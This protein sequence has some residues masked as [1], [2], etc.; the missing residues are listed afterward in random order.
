MIPARIIG[1]QKTTWSKETLEQLDEN[2]QYL[3]IP[4]HRVP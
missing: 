3:A 4:I 2:I 1:A